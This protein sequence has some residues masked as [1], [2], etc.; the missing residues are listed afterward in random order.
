MQPFHKSWQ[1]FNLNNF[2]VSIITLVKAGLL[3]P[4][5]PPSPLHKCIHLLLGFMFNLGC[6]SCSFFFSTLDTVLKFGLSSAY[7]S[8]PRQ[9]CL[10]D[11]EFR[12]TD[13][14]SPSFVSLSHRTDP[15]IY[16]SFLVELCL[17]LRPCYVLTLYIHTFSLLDSQA[18]V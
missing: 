6:T 10:F 9:F 3:V 13:F 8:F 7:Y 12:W 4:I 18:R 5:A 14:H 15:Y 1:H 16:K 11:E 2:L 17:W